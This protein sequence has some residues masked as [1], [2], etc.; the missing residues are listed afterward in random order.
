MIYTIGYGNH[1]IEEFIAKL[2]EKDVKLLI[3]VRT[4][5]FS[6]WNPKFTRSNLEKELVNRSIQYWWRGNNLG[7]LGENIDFEATLDEVAKI[8]S[9]IEA[10][11]MCTESDPL[12]CH[13]HQVLEP[14]FEKRGVSVQHITWVNVETPRLL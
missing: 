3:D 12:K 5:P 11:V 9:T 2:K 8:S 10:V 7:G 4:K 1:K 6:R 13:R 14:E